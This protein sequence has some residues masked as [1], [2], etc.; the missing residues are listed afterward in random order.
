MRQILLAISAMLLFGIAT[1][2]VIS[3]TGYAQ[4]KKGVNATCPEGDCSDIDA[5][6]T[7]DSLVET[8]IKL[9]SWIVGVVSVIMVIFGGFRYITSGG[10]SGK[11]TSA[12]NTIVYALVGLAI[13]ALAQV[14]V[15][16]VLGNV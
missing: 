4:I 7:A 8:I 6:D 9:F 14:L 2:A 5:Q 1:P 15:L 11:V 10:D 12:K 13:A 16:F 3:T